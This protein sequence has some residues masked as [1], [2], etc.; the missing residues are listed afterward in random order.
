MPKGNR[1]LFTP[2]GD[3][4]IRLRNKYVAVIMDGNLSK[5]TGENPD[6]HKN[7][8]KEA[9]EKALQYK[10]GGHGA[11]AVLIEEILWDDI[12]SDATKMRRRK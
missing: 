11:Y 12:P 4:P 1:T 10:A 5:W 8:K 7:A 3:E 2:R 6:I 9:L